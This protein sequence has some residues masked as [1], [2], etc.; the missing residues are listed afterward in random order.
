M[1][2]LDAW[3]A[4]DEFTPVVS[5]EGTDETSDPTEHGADSCDVNSEDDGEVE[6]KVVAPVGDKL[7]REPEPVDELVPD[8]EEAV[9][10]CDID[11]DDGEVEVEV[12][13]SVDG[14]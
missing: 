9:E 10:S 1:Y 7:V 6:V 5:D 14:T 4:S 11:L 2:L 13:A 3:Q 12:V 8:D